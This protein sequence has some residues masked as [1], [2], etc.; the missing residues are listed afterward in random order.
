MLILGLG[1]EIGLTEVKSTL[2]E[3]ARSVVITNDIPTFYDLPLKDARAQFEKAYLDYHLDKNQGS[4]TK[5]AKV[6]GIERTHLYRKMHTLG[7]QFREK[8]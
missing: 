2:G 8:R 7:I 3:P 6:A 5:L 1:D 4:V